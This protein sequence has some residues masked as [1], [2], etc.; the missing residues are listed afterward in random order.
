ME[1]ILENK[2]ITIIN[3]ITG[4]IMD[5]IKL[6]DTFYL[7]LNLFL[8]K[9]LGPN[10][11]YAKLICNN[12]T[13]NSI[14][15]FRVDMGFTMPNDTDIIY[16]IKSYKKNIYIINDNGNYK[17][18]NNPDYNLMDND[19]YYDKYYTI[20]FC[21]P[22]EAYE[23]VINYSRKELILSL[24][25]TITRQKYNTTDFE[26]ILDMIFA[27]EYDDYDFMLSACALTKYVYIFIS[28]K[29]KNNEEFMLNL[30]TQNVHVLEYASINIRNNYNIVLAAVK[31][32]GNIL[33][34]ASEELKDNYDV[35]LAAV[36]IYGN[37]LKYASINLRDNY[38]I[39]LAAVNND[40]FALH[41]ASDNL[42][43]NK[44]NILFKTPNYCN[45]TNKL[46]RRET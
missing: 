13:I 22:M 7:N 21:M 28:D 12:I 44:D 30:I 41:Y 14:N 11:D 5:R 9:Y 46:F 27:H 35:V 32:N 31:I 1:P 15:M 42:R 24:L 23:Q 34:Y 36:T 43:K 38:D 10:E 29:L 26:H 2:Y 18:I 40:S 3:T 16:M 37:A 20:L 6:N 39:V 17:L 25:P 19:P 45:N 4:S 33:Q 8:L